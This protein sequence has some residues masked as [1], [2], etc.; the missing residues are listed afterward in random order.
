MRLSFRLAP[1][2]A[3]LLLCAAP[4][5]AEEAYFKTPS[6]NIF[7]GYDDYSGAPYV[8]CDIRNYTPTTGKTPADCDLEW[9]D[10]FE[11]GANSK[12]G[13]LVCHGDTIINPDARTLGYGKAFSRGG[14]TCLSEQRGLTCKNKRGH[15]F[16]LSRAK[17]QI[18]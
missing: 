3:G 15:G 6:G 13:G 10:S 9:G 1:L 8:R 17:Q 4:A 14:I 11:V 18:F 2:F 12:R 16:F 7:C 5:M